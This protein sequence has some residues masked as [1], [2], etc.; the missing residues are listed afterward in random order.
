MD[1]LAKEN[2]VLRSNT[3]AL[4]AIRQM[5]KLAN[6][7][8]IVIVDDDY[9]APTDAPSLQDVLNVIGS[10]VDIR[11]W[12]EVHRDDLDLLDVDGELIGEDFQVAEISDKWS[13]L[14]P[15]AAREF[16]A[17]TSASRPPTDASTNP[18]EDQEL[19][20]QDQKAILNIDSFVEPVDVIRYSLEQWQSEEDALWLASD[21]PTIVFFDRDFRKEGRSST[22]G[23]KLVEA[24]WRKR[25]PGVYCGLLTH[26]PKTELQIATELAAHLGVADQ[27]SVIAKRRL[28]DPV[29]FA[30]GLRVW[31]SVRELRSLRSAVRTVMADVARKFTESIDAADFYALMSAFESARFE[32]LFEPDALARL[33]RA[34]FNQELEAELRV[35]DLARELDVLR[36]MADMK[37][38]PYG[39]ERPADFDEVLRLEKFIDGSRLSSIH[40]P[41]EAG[42]IFGFRPKAHMSASDS[43]KEHFFVLLVQP[44]DLSLRST[45]RRSNDLEEVVLASVT[46]WPRRDGSHRQLKPTEFELGPLRAGE[47]WIVDVT[48]CRVVNTRVL[49]ACVLDKEGEARISRQDSSP[50]GIAE[51]WSIRSGKLAEWCGRQIDHLKSYDA[52]IATVPKATKEQM[53]KLLLTSLADAG[54]G[55]TLHA[56]TARGTI[57]FGVRRDSRVI[58]DVAR[59]LLVAASQHRSRPDVENDTFMDIDLAHD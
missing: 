17:L 57:R 44:C 38:R 19:V 26:D 33:G 28:D 29:D 48:Q 46:P 35:P 31:L 49:D 7:E 10:G 11:S 43:N 47:A 14:S 1:A 12:A 56:D 58:S 30:I 40:S 37:L 34:V 45:G 18:S 52:H 27:V 8:R 4:N 5:L 53:R 55:V 9:A 15:D 50:P 16:L 2:E 51:G 39:F 3:D 6:I 13:Q 21:K 54:A 23:D 25:L 42:D 32:G 36:R 41:I 59:Y 24:L 22:E 20:E